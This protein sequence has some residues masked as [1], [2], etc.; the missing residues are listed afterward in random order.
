MVSKF[1]FQIHSKCVPLHVGGRD[2]SPYGGDYSFG[3]AGAVLLDDCNFHESADLKDFDTV[4]GG[5][6]KVERS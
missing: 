4:G 3:G 1:A 6:Y 5:L 2:L